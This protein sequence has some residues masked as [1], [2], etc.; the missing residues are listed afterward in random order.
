MQAEIISVGTELLLGQVTDTNQ[1]YLSRQMAELGIDVFFRVTVGDNE[2]RIVEVLK[3]AL[4]R[5]DI[6]LCTG[7][8]GPTEDDLTK[9]AVAQ[10]TGR[11]MVENL[12]ALEWVEAFF[13]HREL[14]MPESNRRQARFPEGA[15]VFPNPVGTAPGAMVFHN[16]KTIVLLPGP[17]REVRPMFETYVRP[18]LEKQLGTGRQVLVSRTLKICGLG[19]SALEERIKDLIL[20]QRNPTIAPLAGLGEVRLRLTAKAESTSEARALLELAAQRVYERVGS[21][22]YGED[23]QTLEET[24]VNLLARNGLSLGV[25]ESCTGGLITDR[26]T[27]VPGV[28]AYLERGVVVYSNRSKHEL[29]G[30]PVRL[31]EQYG[32]VSRQVAEAMA[33]GI[34]RTAGTDLGL[35]VTG[36][37]GPTGGSP[38]KPVGLVYFGLAGKGGTRVFRRVFWGGRVEIKRRAAL[39]ALVLLR[40]YLI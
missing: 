9:Q 10:V 34:R 19:E 5:S 16:G 8:L 28:S 35:G 32:A 33:T 7:G 3:T 13:R 36:I 15:S 24:V 29:L 30:V 20:E 40:R 31:I 38:E 12:R 37:A 4:G 39:E 26:L 27:N 23:D 18:E 14:P 1:V 21:Y 22:I 25:A 2:N 6:V 11:T 17:P